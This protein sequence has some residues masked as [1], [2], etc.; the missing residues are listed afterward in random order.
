MVTTLD[1]EMELYAE[2]DW[3]NCQFDYLDDIIEQNFLPAPDH[4]PLTDHF[5]LFNATVFGG[6]FVIAV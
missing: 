2:D 4:L 3:A 1:L 6:F 5:I